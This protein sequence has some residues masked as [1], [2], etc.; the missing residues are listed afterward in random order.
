MGPYSVKIKLPE[1]TIKE[2]ERRL[3][4]ALRKSTIEPIFGVIKSVIGFTKFSLRGLDSVSGEWSLVCT[5]YNLKRL[6]RLKS[7]VA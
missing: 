2:Q 4:Y 5:A 7:K 1:V 3:F 6:C